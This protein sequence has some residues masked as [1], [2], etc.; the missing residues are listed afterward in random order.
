MFGRPIAMYTKT[1]SLGAVFS[2]RRGNYRVL[3]GIAWQ[4]V[5]KVKCEH[6]ICW[7]TFY[8]IILYF[9][10]CLMRIS[11][12]NAENNPQIRY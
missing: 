6:F 12:N 2:F 11:I 4:Y 3:C 1:P 8:L 5:A 7:I 10:K 9:L